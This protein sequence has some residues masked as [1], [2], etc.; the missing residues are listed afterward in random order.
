MYKCERGAINTLF[1]IVH[2]VFLILLLLNASWMIQSV[3]NKGKSIFKGA[4]FLVSNKQKSTDKTYMINSKDVPRY[5]V[6]DN[7]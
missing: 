3:Q 5:L 7:H 2:F 6:S 1:S 4:T